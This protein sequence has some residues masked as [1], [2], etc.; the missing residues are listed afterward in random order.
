MCLCFDCCRFGWVMLLCGYC[1]SFVWCM[2]DLGLVVLV[3]LV[4]CFV[5]DFAIFALIVLLWCVWLPVV[6]V[7][8]VCRFGLFL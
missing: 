3:G 5:G 1:V 6:I 2:R 8:L 7:V 4:C